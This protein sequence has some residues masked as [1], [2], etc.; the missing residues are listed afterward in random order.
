VGRFAINWGTA[1][2]F[3]PTSNLSAPDFSDPLDYSAKVPNQFVQL[4]IYPTEWFT[5]TV[6]WAP[7]FKPAQVP[8]T[9]VLG[10]AVEYDE[11][12]CLAAAPTPP[13]ADRQEAENLQALFETAGK[14][15]L[16]FLTPD[17]RT[18]MPS[19]TLSNSQVGTRAQFM[20]EDADLEM[21]VSYYYGRFSFPVAYSAIAEVDPSAD[22]PNKMD[23]RYVAEVG[24]PRMQVAGFDF[25]HSASYLGG[26]GIV[27]ELAVIFPE[28]VIFGLRAFQGGTE[29][30]N[31]RASE[32]GKENVNVP[33]DPFV[34][35]TLGMDY[36][37]TEWLYLNVMYV[38]G[39]FDEFNDLYGVHNYAVMATE[40][41]FF[42][43]ELKIRLAAT[44]NADD[45]SAILLPQVTWV[46]YPSIELVWGGLVF[47]GDTVA[48]DPLDYG[49]KSKFGQKSYGRSVAF[50]K[51]K[52]S[53]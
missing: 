1:D 16:N 6:A 29:V 10:F 30:A 4:S 13:I 46:A 17:V 51:A 31:L 22:D 40:L 12:G 5:M 28:K 48:D 49:S 38:R 25:S 27:G 18:V 14:C 45:T 24:Y 11:N 7:L 23:V 44:L 32:K 37:I 9:S 50:F 33:S 2:Q 21:S 26:L 20:I 47:I 41:T 15:N 35:A 19:R 34:K 43:S 8:Y 36:T 42:E 39:F 52:A 3:N 53:W